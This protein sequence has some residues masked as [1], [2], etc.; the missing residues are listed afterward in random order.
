M[1]APNADATVI[2]ALR[3]HKANVIRYQITGAIQAV[4]AYTEAQYYDWV[5]WHINNMKEFL[6]KIGSMKVIIDLH[7]PPGGIHTVTGAPPVYSMFDIRPECREWFKNSWAQI[8]REVGA[9]PNVHAF[10]LLNEPHGDKKQ[11]YNL[12][13]NTIKKIR[14]FSSKPCI[15]S[16]AYGAPNQVK[17]LSIYDQKTLGPVWYTVHMYMP[18]AITHQGIPG[19]GH[20]AGKVYPSPNYNKE[21]LKKDLTNFK[22]FLPHEIHYIGEFSISA[23]ADTQSRVN[24]LRD[25][26]SI[27]EEWG[28]DA[29]Y[30]AWREYGGWDA[31]TPPEVFQVLK[32]WWAKNG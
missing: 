14:E 8:V 24:Y 9:H 17:T 29:C 10:D 7:T 27:F 2:N 11:M 12:M 13:R 26:I 4:G 30:H 25:L 21:R 1:V 20:P 3:V 23:F 19:T 18:L 28:W 31:E 32:D 16:S 5:Q 15:V 6:P 22:N